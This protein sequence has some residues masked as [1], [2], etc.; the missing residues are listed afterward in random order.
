[1]DMDTGPDMEMAMDIDM[2]TD[3]DMPIVEVKWLFT[4]FV[5]QL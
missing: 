3:M 1:M 5:W 4:Y 2:N